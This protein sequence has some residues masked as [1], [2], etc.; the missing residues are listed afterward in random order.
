VIDKK[1]IRGDIFSNNCQGLYSINSCAC[2]D[3]DALGKDAGEDLSRELRD[4]RVETLEG[5][6]LL[7]LERGES[8]GEL[9]VNLSLGSS[10]FLGSLSGD[11]SLGISNLKQLLFSILST[12]IKT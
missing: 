11:S 6:L 7:S 9:T 5:G 1:E 2:L 12:K 3:L 8:A 10:E 4:L